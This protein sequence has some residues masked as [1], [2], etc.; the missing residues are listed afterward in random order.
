MDGGPAWKRYIFI[1]EA[2]TMAGLILWSA[3]GRPIRWLLST[4]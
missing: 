1:A 4:L 2:V 3:L